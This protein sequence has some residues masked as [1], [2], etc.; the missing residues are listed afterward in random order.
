MSSPNPPPLFQ[1][2]LKWLLVAVAVIALLLGFGAFPLLAVLLRVLLPTVAIV[3]AIYSR[4]DVRTFAI[5]AAVSCIPLLTG[6][7]GR[8]GIS[9]LFLGTISQL[10]VM[11]ICGV[12]AVVTQ[13]WLVRR[14]LADGE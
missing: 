6:E 2:S 9:T 5:G 8:P 3:A 1:F 4:G 13:R 14:G 10:A 7:V 11:G 12:A